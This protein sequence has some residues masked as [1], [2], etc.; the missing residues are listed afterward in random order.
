MELRDETGVQR[1]LTERLTRS[2][3]QWIG[4]VERTADD[5]LS[6]RTA[7]LREESKRRLGRPRL[8]WEDC[9]K[10]DEMRAGEEEY[11]KKKTSDSGGWKRLS[12]ETVA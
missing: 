8:K 10:I 12:D 3:L 2:R 6:K 9:V 5:R 11:W 1:S 7:E 4:Y